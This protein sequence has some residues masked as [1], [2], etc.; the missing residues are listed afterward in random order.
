LPGSE[1][2]ID[3]YL[4]R[5]DLTIACETSFETTIDHEVGNV[6]KCLRAGIGMIAVICLEQTRL[7][8]IKKAVVGTFSQDEA[9]RVKY[10]EPTEFI[11]YLKNLHVP[12]AQQTEPKKRAGRTVKRTQ[13]AITADERATREAEYNRALAEAL[14]K[15][16]ND[17]CN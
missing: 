1:K 5:N 9:A 4:E 16:K 7:A 6:L 17:Q 13:S 14:K 10:F 2:R 15:K 11:S 8:K 3:V 12:P